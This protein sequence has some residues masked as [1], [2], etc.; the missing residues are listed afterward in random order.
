MAGFL[1]HWGY[2]IGSESEMLVNTVS[3]VQPTVTTDTQGNSLEFEIVAELPYTYEKQETMPGRPGGVAFIAQNAGTDLFGFADENFSPHDVYVLYVLSPN[4][5]SNI[6]R[7]FE[8]G[9]YF[10]LQIHSPDANDLVI[11]SKSG[12]VIS[13]SVR[14]MNSEFSWRV[15]QFEGP[16][17]DDTVSV[18]VADIT[19]F[20][21]VGH[22]ALMT[23]T[24]IPG[25]FEV[26]NQGNR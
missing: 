1:V 16:I 3:V 23:G 15:V 17:G 13:K 4:Q 24:L 26:L 5:V 11:V 14:D 22:V 18:S 19:G 21:A 6:E 7:I 12:Q 8:V 10:V 25:T 9:D 2:T 20:K